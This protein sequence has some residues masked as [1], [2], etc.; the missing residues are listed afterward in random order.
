MSAGRG[1]SIA[2]LGADGS[3][4]STLVESVLA[5]PP[6]GLDVR[7]VKVSV[8]AGREYPIR[9]LVWVV[10]TGRLLMLMVSARLAVRRGA[11]LLWDRHPVE[12]SV[13][14][15]FGRQ[16]LGARRGWLRWLVPPPDLLIVLDAPVELLE[17]RRRPEEAPDGL[18]AMREAFLRLADGHPSVVLDASAQRES[19]RGQVVD[20]IGLLS[21]GHVDP[22]DRA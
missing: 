12:D 2:I 11:V 9:G 8:H 1:L 19:V 4:K 3:G 18:Q 14:K 15:P 21:G 6:L 13:L 7:R 22:S 17:S 5:D 10:R 20:V 16:V